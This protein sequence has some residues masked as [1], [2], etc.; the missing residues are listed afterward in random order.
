[1]QM[2][3]DS[4]NGL[5]A[6]FS[7]EVT[8]SAGFRVLRGISQNLPTLIQWGQRELLHHWRESRLPGPRSEEHLCIFAGGLEE[9]QVPPPPSL[10]RD[11]GCGSLAF[12]PLLCGWPRPHSVPQLILS[13]NSA[14][15][16][17]GSLGVQGEGSRS[18]WRA[19]AFEVGGP[20]RPLRSHLHP[21][22]LP[23]EH[24]QQTLPVLSEEPGP[25]SLAEPMLV[26]T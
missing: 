6:P 21:G 9:G 11:P 25:H 19:D 8:S 13:H 23:T 12:R 20:A 2:R 26:S 15:S 14:P 3:A 17:A 18:H 22:G 4:A 5:S 1:M 24:L 7:W 16:S 10:R